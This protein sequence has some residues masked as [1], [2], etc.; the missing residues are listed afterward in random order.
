MREKLEREPRAEIE[1][2]DE[3]L[4]CTAGIDRIGVDLG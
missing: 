2:D 3:V 4:E 1:R